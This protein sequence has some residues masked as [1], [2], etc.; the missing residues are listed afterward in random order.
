MLAAGNIFKCYEP[1]LKTSGQ[2][3]SVLASLLLIERGF[4]LDCLMLR[5]QGIYLYGFAFKHTSAGIIPQPKKRNEIVKLET[6]VQNLLAA[7]LTEMTYC[8]PEQF[9]FLKVQCG[10]TKRR[11]AVML[12]W[13]LMKAKTFTMASA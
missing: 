7:I 12:D 1:N 10:E 11:G 2:V 5:Y 3:S 6:R 13:K 8:I 4:T 9:K